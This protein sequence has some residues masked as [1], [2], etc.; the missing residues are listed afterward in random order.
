MKKSQF[1]LHPRLDRFPLFGFSSIAESQVENRGN[2]P[3]VCSDDIRCGV[4]IDRLYCG[5]RV[6][7]CYRN[8][9]DLTVRTYLEF[10][11]PLIDRINQYLVRSCNDK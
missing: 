11:H 10:V 9:L 1:G 6:S 4:G 3:F 5:Q 7:V 2:M 8:S